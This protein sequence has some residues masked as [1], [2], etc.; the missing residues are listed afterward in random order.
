MKYVCTWRNFLLLWSKR[1][2][3]SKA[4]LRSI[5]CMG[6]NLFSEKIRVEN[7]KQK[8]FWSRIEEDILKP[9]ECSNPIVLIKYAGMLATRP[10]KKPN[11]IPCDIEWIIRWQECE[12]FQKWNLTHSF[13]LWCCLIFGHPHYATYVKMCKHVYWYLFQASWQFYQKNICLI[14]LAKSLSSIETPCIKNRLQ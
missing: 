6:E 13:F 12:I 9:Y 5:S 8:K 4:T 14:V 2:N 11:D 7:L 10:K 3:I 1:S